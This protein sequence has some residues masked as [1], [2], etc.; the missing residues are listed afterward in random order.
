MFILL[1]E[2]EIVETRYSRQREMILTYL[3]NTTDHP[4]AEM[5]YDNI[6]RQMPSISLGTVYRNLAF[7]ADSGKIIRIQM[8]DDN[9]RFDAQ[10]F[11]HYHWRCRV[12]GE[13]GDLDININQQLDEEAELQ[14]GMI[15]ERHDL[16]FIGVCNNCSGAY[17]HNGGDKSYNEAASPIL[18]SE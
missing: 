9:M 3:S 15:V 12:C 18:L 10:T 6:R 8:R 17:G 2:G 1:M 5:V 4:T 11:E 13:V 7:L 16:F 14:T